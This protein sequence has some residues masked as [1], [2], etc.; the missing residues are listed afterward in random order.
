M[1]TQFSTGV[2]TDRGETIPADGTLVR[3]DISGEQGQ[4]FELETVDA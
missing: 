1:S 3:L 2:Q 4:V